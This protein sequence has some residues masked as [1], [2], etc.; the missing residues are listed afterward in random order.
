MNAISQAFRAHLSGETTTL[1]HCWRVTRRDGNVAGYTD[2]DQPL[3]VDG[4]AFQPETGFSASE[5]RDRLGLSTDTVDI[6][7]AL[8]S[9]DISDAEIAAGLFDG[10]GVETLLVNWSDPNQWTLLRKAVIGKIV[11]SDGQFTAELL[12]P[13][14]SLD[15]VNGRFIRR[16]CDA[17]LGD[18]RCKVALD[19]PGFHASGVVAEIEGRD[20]VLVSGLNDVEAGW[21]SH[22]QLTWL[23][24]ANAG[25]IEQVLDHA[26][27]LDGVRLMLWRDG[28]ITSAP[29]D[30]F[31]VEVGCD[32]LFATCRGKFGNG[33][34]FRGFPHLPGNDAAYGYVT[35]GV[36]FDGAPL[37]P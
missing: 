27:R 32:K 35:D 5:A 14:E 13:T 31:T 11:R 23:S 21:F 16:S 6:D 28:T 18:H 20:A 9:L 33:L 30:A 29:G 2:H 22:G 37:V 8:S 12:S 7:G 4:T 24:G 15:R 19:R 26:R 1:C 17:V 3:M 10:A 36:V 25:R 34:N